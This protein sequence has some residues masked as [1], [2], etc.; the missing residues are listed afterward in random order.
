MDSLV[1]PRFS[2][3]GDF[4]AIHYPTGF[5]MGRTKLAALASAL[6]IKRWHLANAAVVRAMDAARGAGQ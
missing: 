3:I 6:R 2:R 4:D 1:C 5:T